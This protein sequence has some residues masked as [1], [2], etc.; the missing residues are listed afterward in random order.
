MVTE[1]HGMHHAHKRK[2]IH[3]HHEEFPH[4]HP[5]KR[6]MDKAIFIVGF[7]SPIMTLPMLYKIFSLQTAAGLSF[8][9]YLTY[10]F[11]T[12]FWFLYGVLHKEKPIYVTNAVWLVLHVIILIGIVMYG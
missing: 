1:T 10:L 9:S 12:A 4:P 6:F 3:E 7:I 2:R 11:T 5:F 8:I